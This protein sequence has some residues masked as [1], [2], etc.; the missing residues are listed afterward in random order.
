[1]LPQDPIMLL[2]FLNMKLRDRYSSLSD[3]CEDL[4]E[5]E[6]DIVTK[7]VEAG[8]RYDS[9]NNQFVMK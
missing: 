1:M 9:E 6:A 2:S 7:M 5:N 8:Y 3:L 4:D